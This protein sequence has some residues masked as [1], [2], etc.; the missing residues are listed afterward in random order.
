MVEYTEGSQAGHAL[1]NPNCEINQVSFTIAFLNENIGCTY[2]IFEEFLNENIKNFLY[3]SGA[4]L[5]RP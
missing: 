3:I 5:A 4:F 1:K 2:Y